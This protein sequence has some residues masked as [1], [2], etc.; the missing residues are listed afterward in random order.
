MIMPEPSNQNDTVTKP[1]L[2]IVT[3]L[4]RILWAKPIPDSQRDHARQCHWRPAPYFISGEKL[5][6]TLRK[7][8][9]FLRFI[10]TVTY[11]G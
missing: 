1:W 7:C 11:L 3:R 2:P 4:K 9:A 10:P 8:F 5:P 6:E